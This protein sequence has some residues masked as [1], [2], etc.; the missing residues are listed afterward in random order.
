MGRDMRRPSVPLPWG[1]LLAVAGQN[2]PTRVNSSGVT[3]SRQFQ[4]ASLL[5]RL[6]NEKAITREIWHAA[7]RPSSAERRVFAAP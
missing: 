3:A 2:R 5:K 4:R 7:V 1:H 6:I